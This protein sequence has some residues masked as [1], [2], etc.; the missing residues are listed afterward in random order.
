[1]IVRSE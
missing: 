1:V